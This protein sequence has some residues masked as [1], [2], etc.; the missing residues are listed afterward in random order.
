M[1]LLNL[2]TTAVASIDAGRLERRVREIYR[3]GPPLGRRTWGS[4]A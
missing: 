1:T 4:V 3:I 2:Q